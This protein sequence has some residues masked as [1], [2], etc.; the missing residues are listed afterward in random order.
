M[1]RG[2]GLATVVSAATVQH[3]LRLGLEPTWSCFT[4]NEGSWRITEKLG[5]KVR[6]KKS[7]TLWDIYVEKQH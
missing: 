4:F 1:Y 7:I 6:N 2:Q 5:F 3:A